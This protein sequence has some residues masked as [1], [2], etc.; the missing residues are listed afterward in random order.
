MAG[1]N[2][3]IF[4]QEFDYRTWDARQFDQ[5]DVSP[6][7]SKAV[8]LNDAKRFC[9]SSGCSSSER[10]RLIDQRHT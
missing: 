10:D 7:R 4:L 8:L 3:A 1:R 5:F 6:N 9:N 2:E